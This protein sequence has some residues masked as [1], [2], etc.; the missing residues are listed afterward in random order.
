M[1]HEIILSVNTVIVNN[2]L[3]IFYIFGEL[4]FVELC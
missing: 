3:I 1:N 2:I 4:D